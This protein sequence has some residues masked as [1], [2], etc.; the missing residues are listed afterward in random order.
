MTDFTYQQFVVKGQERE[1]VILYRGDKPLALFVNE[2]AK[3]IRFVLET[4]NINARAMIAI[5]P[6]SELALIEEQAKFNEHLL[7]RLAFPNEFL[8]THFVK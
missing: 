3:L 7:P 6:E 4:V 5:V 2:D 1:G 8:K